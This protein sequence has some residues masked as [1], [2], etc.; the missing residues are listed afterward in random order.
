MKNILLEKFKNN[1]IVSCQAF[2]DEPLNDTNAI[3]LMAKS[4]V[5]GG[6]KALRLCQKDHIKQIMTITDLPMMCLIKADYD[7]SEVFITPTFKEVD[8]LIEIG[9][10][11][12]ATDATSRK[13]PNQSLEE[14]V[15][16]IR[17]KD[18]D[19]L[20]MA[21]CATIEDVKRADQLG[22]DLIGTTLTGNTKE[23]KGLNII[24]NNYQFIRDCLNATNKPII[25]EGGIWEPYEV[26]D[27]LDLGCYGVVVGSAITRPRK[28]TEKFMKYLL[29]NNK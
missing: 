2:D 12:I 23:S 3:G 14:I 19:I 25:A 28:I 18:K 10:R 24:S 21:D 15:N 4:V 17:S 5:Q 27:L 16:Y 11:C 13:R 8:D 1:L 9:A 20:I 6:A 29:E 22:F 7:N 26:K